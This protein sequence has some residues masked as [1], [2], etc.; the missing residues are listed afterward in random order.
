[1][2]C[3]NYMYGSTIIERNCVAEFD[4]GRN[5]LDRNCYG[6]V[7]SIGEAKLRSEGAKLGGSG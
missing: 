7:I 1:M 5:C 2:L 3:N 6:H 4:T